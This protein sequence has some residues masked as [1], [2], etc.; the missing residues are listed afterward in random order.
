MM[1]DKTNRSYSSKIIKAGALLSDTKN[2]LANWDLSLSTAENLNRFRQENLFGK[3]SRSRVEDIL[4]VFRQRFLTECQVTKALVTL[5]R[6]AF[7]A[8]ILDRVLYFHAAQSDN[9]LHDIVTDV[10]FTMLSDG[11]TEVTVPAI[12]TVIQRWVSEGKT[13]GQWNETTSHRVTQGLL[14]TLRDFGVLRGGTNK[15]IAIINL[16]VTAFSYIAFYLQQK[17]PS[18]ERLL[19]HPDWRLFFLSEESVE[20]LFMEAHQ[21][22]LLEYHAAGSIIR[23]TFPTDSLEEYADALAKRTN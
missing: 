20:H 1:S 17:Q 4:I 12:Q 15:R 9:L 7:P 5:V 18:G 19:D 21:H 23:I 10:L 3:A 16:P 2:L 13:I 14:A 11:R 8:E 22:R 6:N